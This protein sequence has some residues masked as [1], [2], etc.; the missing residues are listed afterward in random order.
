MCRQV[1]HLS[2]IP[3]G[4]VACENYYGDY[5]AGVLEKK[6]EREFCVYH[7]VHDTADTAVKQIICELKPKQKLTEQPLIST[8]F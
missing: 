2:S 1:T 3:F 7:V 6:G 8:E 4:N 5:D